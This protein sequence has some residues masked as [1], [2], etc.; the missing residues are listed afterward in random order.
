MPAEP[1]PAL[2]E[3]YSAAGSLAGALDDLR[4]A[5]DGASIA[6]PGWASSGRMAS[7]LY[8]FQVTML[9]VSRLVERVL[10]AGGASLSGG[11]WTLLADP[12]PS[13]EAMVSVWI[14][15]MDHQVSVIGPLLASTDPAAAIAVTGGADWCEPA[16]T[17][18][19][20]VDMLITEG[21]GS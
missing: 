12:A 5:V 13:T 21:Q 18:S 7:V 8:D 15:L 3:L 6:G 9:E 11:V 17:L 2:A 16:A 4:D 10:D 19:A 14:G 20:A 1:D